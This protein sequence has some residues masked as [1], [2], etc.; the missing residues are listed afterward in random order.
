MRTS[1]VAVKEDG[2]LN[3]QHRE[4]R[5]DDRAV[6][7]RFRTTGKSTVRARGDGKRPNA[8]PAQNPGEEGTQV[9]V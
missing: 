3:V 2:K 9:I 8:P 1:H 5:G 4:E 6:L 7:C